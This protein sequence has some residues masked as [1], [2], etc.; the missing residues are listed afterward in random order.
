MINQQTSQPASGIPVLR[1]AVNERMASVLARSSVHLD[2]A[3]LGDAAVIMLTTPTTVRYDDRRHPDLSFAVGTGRFVAIDQSGGWVYQLNATP[4]D[5]AA[6]L[7][8]TVGVARALGRALRTTAWRQ[9]HTPPW[10]A[11]GDAVAVWV[12]GQD[13]ELPVA[14]FTAGPAEVA[15]T[16]KRTGEPSPSDRFLGKTA[17]SFY[18]NLEVSDFSRLDAYEARVISRRRAHGDGRRSLRLSAFMND[19]TPP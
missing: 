8:E 16:L 5:R 19:T 9:D 2:P 13:A 3:A 6:P 17:E 1:V 14:R 11:T 15:I 4:Q 7:D 18:V 10:V 12:R